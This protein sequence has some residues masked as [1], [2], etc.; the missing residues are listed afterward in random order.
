MIIKIHFYAN[1]THGQISHKLKCTHTLSQTSAHISSHTHTHILTPTLAI[2]I[3]TVEILP[4]FEL[5][6]QLLS[7]YYSHCIPRYLVSNFINCIYRPYNQISNSVYNA[8]NYEFSFISVQYRIYYDTYIIQGQLIQYQRNAF[9]SN[10]FCLNVLQFYCY[11]LAIY[12]KYKQL[13]YRLL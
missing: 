5:Y 1:L 12:C 8:V 2:L 4:R 10:K 9:S 7:V 6:L 13:L 3:V 11:L